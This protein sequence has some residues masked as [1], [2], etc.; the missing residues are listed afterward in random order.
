MPKKPRCALAIVLCFLFLFGLFGCFPYYANDGAFATD[1]GSKWVSTDP[2]IWFVNNGENDKFWLSGALMY[3]GRTID[4]S[5]G[6]VS[7]VVF[8]IVAIGTTGVASLD[9]PDRGYFQ[10]GTHCVALLS[11]AITSCTNDKL[12]VRVDY[13]YLPD[14]PVKEIT[15]MRDFAYNPLP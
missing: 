12:V 4:I 15:F 13:N 1:T 14:F 8:D 5:I 3:K 2:D 7:R 6:T 11:C 10:W 9:D